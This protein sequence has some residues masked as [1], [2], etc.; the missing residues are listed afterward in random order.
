MERLF[1]QGTQPVAVCISAT[2]HFKSLFLISSDTAGIAA[3]RPP[4][5]GPRRDRLQRQAGNWGVTK[6]KLAIEMLTDVDLTLRS[7]GQKAPS[8]ALVQRV[9]IRLAMIATR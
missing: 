6:S 7:S 4:V 3:L 9:M 8:I 1:S 5:Y 2:R